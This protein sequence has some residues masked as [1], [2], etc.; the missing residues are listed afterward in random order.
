M[1]YLWVFFQGCFF[2]QLFRTFNELKAPVFC[3]F[4]SSLLYIFSVYLEKLCTYIH[5]AVN[6]LPLIARVIR[7]NNVGWKIWPIL[8]SLKHEET[9]WLHLCISET[10]FQMII[11][12]CSTIKSLC[13]RH[14]NSSQVHHWTGNLS[15]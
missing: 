2:I 6:L 4:I 8:S 13:C 10:K 15:K 11:K 14:S 12:N 3:D 9:S 7:N 1:N 5:W